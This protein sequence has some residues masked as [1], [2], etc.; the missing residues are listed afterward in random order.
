MYSAPAAFERDGYFADE[1]DAS[2][3]EFD[4]EGHERGGRVVDQQRGGESESEI[5][6]PVE[7]QVYLKV[8]S[9]LL[10]L[11]LLLAWQIW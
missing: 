5:R 9:R 11:L 8:G 7:M 1:Y 4:G 3:G 6:M 2:D 10:W